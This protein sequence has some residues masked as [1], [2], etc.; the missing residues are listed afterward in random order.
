MHSLPV[1]C[2]AMGYSAS[3]YLGELRIAPALRDTLKRK[4]MTASVA[5][6]RARLQFPQIRPI[7]LDDVFTNIP[8]RNVNSAELGFA[9]QQ[10]GDIC[11]PEAN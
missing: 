7:K 10:N 1:F 8:E 9:L 3:I 5:R 11:T 4:A 6:A 2:G